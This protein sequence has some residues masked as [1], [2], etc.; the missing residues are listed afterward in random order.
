MPAQGFFVRH[1]KRLEMSH[2]EIQP[3]A[4]DPRPAFYLNDVQRAD[5]I[6]VTSP[7]PA[8][9][10]HQTSDFLVVISRAAQETTLDTVD[11]RTL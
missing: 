2:V 1:L 10:L 9:S 6:S 3:A 4:P 5:F 7:K 8:F 11:S